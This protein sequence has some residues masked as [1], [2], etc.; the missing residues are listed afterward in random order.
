VRESENLVLI[1]KNITC[2]GLKNISGY[3]A[4]VRVSV[5]RVILPAVQ[6]PISSGWKYCRSWR[7][8]TWLRLSS[9]SVEKMWDEAISNP[10]VFQVAMARDA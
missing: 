5:G 9:L 2:V 4:M 8:E 6:L 7:L 1:T 10:F 3:G